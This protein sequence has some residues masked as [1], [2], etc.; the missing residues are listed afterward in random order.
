ISSLYSLTYA[1]PISFY[2]KPILYRL[3]L[4]LHG[5]SSPF[6]PQFY[7]SLAFSAKK[8]LFYLCVNSS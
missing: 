7:E 1:S 4:F 2:I 8:D 3:M 6:L 5:Y